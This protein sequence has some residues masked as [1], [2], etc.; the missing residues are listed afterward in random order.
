MKYTL[1]IIFFAL[2]SGCQSTTPEPGIQGEAA[3]TAN[4]PE[5]GYTT[6]KPVKL[7]GFLRGSKYEG[8][9]IEYFQSLTGPNGEPV[10]VKRLGSC[11][12][13]EDQSMPFGGG[14]LDKY[15]LSYPGQKKPVIIYVNLYQFEAPKAPQGFTLL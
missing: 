5:Y 6:H 10:Q 4:D 12:P 7:G 3:F 1:L 2:L 15:Q 9:H 11:C 14:M 13:F 8:S